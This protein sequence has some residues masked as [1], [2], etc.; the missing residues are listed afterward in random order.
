[1]YHD[2]Q[3]LDLQRALE[4]DG[5][6]EA[7]QQELVDKLKKAQHL[8][9][10]AYEHRQQAVHWQGVHDWLSA[11]VEPSADDSIDAPVETQLAQ[12]CTAIKVLHQQAKTMVNT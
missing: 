10:E 12:Y 6:L 3:Q 8:E 4:L 5:Q 11:S 9:K 1:M 7:R 2:C